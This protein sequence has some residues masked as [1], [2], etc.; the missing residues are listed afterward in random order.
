MIRRSDGDGL[1]ALFTR[2]RAIRLGI[3]AEGQETAQPD[4]GRRAAESDEPV[5]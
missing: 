3:V 2:T 5:S 1:F 4:F